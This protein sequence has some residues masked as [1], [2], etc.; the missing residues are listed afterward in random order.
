MSAPFVFVSTHRI[1]E[2]GADQLRR[3]VV[4][5]DEVSARDDSLGSEFY[6]TP[7]GTRLTHL[8]VQPDAAAMDRHLQLVGEWIGPALAL[9]PTL[10]IDVFGT[11]GPALAAALQHNAEAGADV[12][13]HDL[14]LDRDRIPADVA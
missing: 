10:T 6:V 11:P 9:A 7:D 4:R 3:L 2:G 8:Q 14:P 1:V 13:V 12:R 5:F